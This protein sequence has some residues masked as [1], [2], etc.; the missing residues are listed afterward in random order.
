MINLTYQLKRALIIKLPQ[1]DLQIR[2]LI[3]QIYA[4]FFKYLIISVLFFFNLSVFCVRCSELYILCSYSVI[5][6]S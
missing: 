6:L 2:K 4:I 5:F 3:C 1:P